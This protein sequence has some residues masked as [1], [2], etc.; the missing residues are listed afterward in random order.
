MHDKMIIHNPPEGSPKAKSPKRSTQAS[1]LKSITYL[2]P[3]LRRKN[4]IASIKSVSDTCDI[5]MMIAGYFTVTRSLYCGTFAKSCRKVS[6][7][8]LVNCNAAPRSIEKAKKTANFGV[9]NRVK[10]FK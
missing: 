8:A 9:L 3:N 2:I 5:D 7:Y 4:G 10:A 1:I 6:P